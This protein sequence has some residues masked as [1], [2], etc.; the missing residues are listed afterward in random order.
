MASYVTVTEIVTQTPYSIHT[1]VLGGTTTVYSSHGST[2]TSASV[3]SSPTGK[4]SQNGTSSSDTDQSKGVVVVYH[5]SS[6]Q[7]FLGTYLAVLIAVVYRVIWTLIY[8]NFNLVEP[9]R[10]LSES[11][12]AAAERAFFSFYQS[13]SNL[14]GPLPAILRRRWALALAATAYLIACIL[15][16]LASETIYVDTNWG[17]LDPTSGKNPCRPRMTANVTILRVI[18]GLLVLGAIGLLALTSVLL[19]TKTGLPTHPSSMATVASVL[20]PAL[21][22][23]FNEV[24][25][26]ASGDSMARAMHGRRYRLMHYKDTSGAA[27]Y[28]IVPL[29]VLTAEDQD[30]R[31]PSTYGDGHHY[32]P[33]K[34]SAFETDEQAASS[35]MRPMDF[36]LAFVVLGAFSV[37]LAYYLDNDLKDGFNIFFN[38]NTFGPRFILTGAG[39]V[40][41]TLWKTTEQSAT[42]MAPY[43]RLAKR[44]S[45]A[46]STILFAPS[47]TPVMSTVTALYH[48]YFFIAAVT[49]TTFCAEALNIVISGVPY[50]AGQTWLQ[51]LVSAYISIGVLSVMILVVALVIFSRRAEPKIPRKPDTLGAVMSYM[52]GSRMLDDFDGL[53]GQGDDNRDRRVRLLRKKYVFKKMTRRDGK[54]AW[55]VDEDSARLSY[56][57]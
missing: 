48:R 16:A 21:L 23:D 31:V 32:E 20:S 40:I 47:N 12:G 57:S 1:T 41:A 33:V 10:Q 56:R 52:A 22:E 28:G 49:G 44:P 37:V 11:D 2:I 13:Q 8:S 39:T 54:Y 18:Q 15:P 42:I 26:D 38:S 34:S 7:T 46:T 5:W 25:A 43:I 55:T 50:A 30:E 17:C 51:F 3:A 45:S 19:I 24:P 4:D 9:F 36:L 27:G 14:L 29:T 53:N 35:R 6:E